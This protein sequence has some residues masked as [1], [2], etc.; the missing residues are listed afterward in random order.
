MRMLLGWIGYL[1]VGVALFWLALISRKFGRV[2]HAAPYYIGLLVAAALVSL[3]AVV[4]MV[5]LFIPV[6][7]ELSI[8]AALVYHGLPAM[9][10]T[11]GL[12]FAW[13]YWSWLLAER[14]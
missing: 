9:G 6:L 1:A 10:V 3:S 14:D 8:L 5:T 2:T 7:N 12:V 4:R 11:I 13:R